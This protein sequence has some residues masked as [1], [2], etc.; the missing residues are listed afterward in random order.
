MSVKSTQIDNQ[1]LVISAKKPLCK[2]LM[3][4]CF[5]LAFNIHLYWP[6]I[7][8]TNVIEINHGID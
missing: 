1:I 7:L 3:P 5:V 2:T 6:Y 8:I 4:F